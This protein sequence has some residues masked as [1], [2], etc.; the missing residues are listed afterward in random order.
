MVMT[1]TGLVVVVH[2]NLT[3]QSRRLDAIGSFELNHRSLTVRD[4]GNADGL[5]F[6][7]VPRII[8]GL[9]VISWPF[10]REH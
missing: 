5:I 10:L 1:V 8:V 9:T 7:T 4:L 3:G 6:R 2:Q